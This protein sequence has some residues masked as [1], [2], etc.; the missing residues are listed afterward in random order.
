MQPKI[1][2]VKKRQRFAN[3][4][5]P[6]HPNCAH[7]D[8]V[9]LVA[10]FMMKNP[11]PET[12]IFESVDGILWNVKLNKICDQLDKGKGTLHFFIDGVQQLVFV[13]GINEPVRFYGHIY[14]RG[15]SFTIVT[16]KNLP[17]T[18]TQTLS[19]EKAVDWRLQ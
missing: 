13:R 1:E 17:A 18:T 3:A 7:V 9:R 11:D 5:F 8:V 10:Q 2:V 14:D 6:A 4:L 15:A 19:N 16:F 12:V